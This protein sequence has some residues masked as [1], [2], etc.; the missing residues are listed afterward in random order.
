MVHNENPHASCINLEMVSV[1]C[2]LKSLE[3]P[4][5]V[6]CTPKPLN[7]LNDFCELY[8]KTIQTISKFMQG[9]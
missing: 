6:S 5:S 1:S 8:S 3:G 7:I 9:V 4:V 2:T